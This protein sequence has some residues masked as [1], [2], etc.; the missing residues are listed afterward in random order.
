MLYNVV[1]HSVLELSLDGAGYSSLQRWVCCEATK[2]CLCGQMACHEVCMFAWKKVRLEA[3]PFLASSWQAL[4]R[5]V[6][7]NEVIAWRL[8]RSACRRLQVGK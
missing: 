2:V 4:H 7:G 5:D 6:A 1:K 3:A 8:M